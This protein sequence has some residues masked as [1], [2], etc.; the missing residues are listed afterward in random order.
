[1]IGWKNQFMKNLL[2]F[3]TMAVLA[4]FFAGCTTTGPAYKTVVD[5][6]PPLAADA[7][8][9]FIYRDAVF[10][11]S[12]MPAILLSG[13]QVGLARAQGFFYVDRPAGD[14]KVAISGENSPPASFTLSPGQ[15][16]YVRINVHS[17]F[18]IDPHSNLVMN[19]LYPGVVDATIA[20]R[21][22][23][24]CKYTGDAQK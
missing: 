5:S 3:L 13:E 23:V 11:P 12:K 21:E 4:S 9:I 20:Q 8:R 18:G 10:N 17:N 6:C 16:L 14:Y 19:H 2:T 24:S 7:G 22:L 1:M 15:T